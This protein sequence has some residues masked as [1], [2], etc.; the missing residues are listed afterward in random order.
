MTRAPGHDVLVAG[1]GPAGCVAAVMLARAGAR[2][3]LLDRARFPRDKLCGD[4]L[5]P[6]ARALLRRLGLDDVESGGVRLEGMLVSGP[7]GVQIQASYPSSLAG[8]AI[9]RRQLD[10]A[11]LARA[12]AAGVEV[13]QEVSVADPASCLRDGTGSGLLVRRR[14]GRLVEVRA[15]IVI[16][17]DGRSSRLARALRLASY[18]PAPR[19]WAVGG[20][21]RDAAGMAARGEMHIRRGL[22]IGVAPLPGELTNVCVVTADRRRLRDPGRLLTATL[23]GDPLL[24]DRFE[25][26]DLIAP[27]ISLG[28]LAVDCAVPGAPGLLLAGDAAGFVDPM[29]GDGLRFALR[30]AELA[31]EEALRVL[32]TGDRTAHLRLAGR[33]RREFGAKLRFNRTLRRL[34]DSPAALRLA[35]RASRLSAWPVA[36]IVRY[37]GDGARAGSA[38][39]VLR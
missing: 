6:G 14:G 29:T 39:P 22:Y 4:T 23:S 30:G 7:D 21:F 34:V 18:A 25:A 19:R 20:Y 13:E 32:E 11:L 38:V 35:C 36:R 31:A 12:A 33:R 26:A 17:A 8:C 27:P 3:L 24:A 28:P 10:H 5:N 9:L 16:A 1:A 37:A 2:V 15:R